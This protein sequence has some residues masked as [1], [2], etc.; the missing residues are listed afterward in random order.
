MYLRAKE[1]R[2][3]RALWPQRWARSLSHRVGL[4]EIGTRGT[5]LKNEGHF[6]VTVNTSIIR[7]NAQHSAF[8]NGFDDWMNGESKKGGWIGG[9]GG[10]KKGRLS[11]SFWEHRGVWGQVGGQASQ[12]AS[13]PCQDPAQGLARSRNRRYACWTSHISVVFTGLTHPS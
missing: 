5:A 8:Q 13:S 12:R 4:S 7:L 9:R 10:G 2:S 3:H 1:R 11:M 6:G